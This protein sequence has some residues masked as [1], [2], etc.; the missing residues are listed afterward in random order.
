MRAILAFAP[1]LGRLKGPIAL[2]L[3]LSLI[4]LLAGIGLLG[5]SGWFLTAAALST[6]GS[7]FNIFAPSAGV[8][9]L[10]FIRI[11]SRYGE[12]LSGHDM[13]LRLQNCGTRA[14]W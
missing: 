3:L 4:T 8:R 7:A 14:R 1:L 13:T 5:L 9:G 12:K 6:L 10:S 2:T 11:L